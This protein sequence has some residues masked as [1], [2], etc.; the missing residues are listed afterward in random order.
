MCVCL[1]ENGR[2]AIQGSGE[3]R[4]EEPQEVEHDF[5][6]TGDGVKERDTGEGGRDHTRWLEG[7]P[8]QR[9]V[10]LEVLRGQEGMIFLL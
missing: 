2:E 7:Y 8:N 5:N 1:P 9:T 6:S 3:D 4:F 10:I